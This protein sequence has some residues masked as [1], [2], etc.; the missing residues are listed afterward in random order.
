VDTLTR[1]I[2]DLRGK[3]SFGAGA[4]KV[5]NRNREMIH[6]WAQT[7]TPIIWAIVSGAVGFAIADKL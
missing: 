7:F 1:E 5:E 3:I 6:G 2:A 4:T